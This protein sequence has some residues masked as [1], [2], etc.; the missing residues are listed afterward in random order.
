M[1]RSTDTPG[2]VESDQD[3]F[4]RRWVRGSDVAALVKHMGR[5]IPDAEWDAAIQAPAKPEASQDI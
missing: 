3:P 1:S 5:V 2:P 4:A